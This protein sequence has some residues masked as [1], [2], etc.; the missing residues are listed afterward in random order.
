[1]DE[2]EVSSESGDSGAAEMPETREAPRG[3]RQVLAL[4]QN[5]GRMEE[6]RGKANL[7]H[8][9]RYDRKRRL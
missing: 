4:W 7:K 6:P 2:G 9:V 8:K 5:A 3:G 1:V